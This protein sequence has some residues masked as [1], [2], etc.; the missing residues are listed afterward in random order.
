MRSRLRIYLLLALLS[1]LCRGEAQTVATNSLQQNVA[2]TPK[3]PSRAAAP[4]TALA[5]SP[6]GKSV[7]VGGYRAVRL[8]DPMT[9]SL[10]RTLGGAADQ[11]QAVAWNENGTRLA[12]AGGVPGQSGEVLIFDPA[13]GQ[14]VQRLAGHEE[15]VCAVAWRPHS[16]ELAA[17]SLDKTVRLWDTTTG[18]P[19]RLLKEHADAVYSVAWSPD[20]KLLASGGADRSVKLFDTTTW[21]VVQTLTVHQDTVTQIAF[22]PAGTLLMTASADKTLAV[23]NVKIGSM[24]TPVRRPG[25][26]EMVN[27]CRYSADG[28]LLVCGTAG[29]E[30]KVWNGD[31]AQEKRQWRDAA[32][33][34]YSVAVTPDNRYTLAGTLDGKVFFWDIATGKRV[35]TV[36][37]RPEGVTIE[38]AE[39]GK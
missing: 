5:C 25:F 39:A 34:V 16:L 21:K 18:K 24:E 11:V 28:T 4:V 1:V 20:G 14:I 23:W 10:L 36:T 37:V 32:D 27:A 3:P 7:A 26:G 17:G 38:T 30:V 22:H 31:A 13:T 19:L 2:P 9:G 35:R 6:D 8:L 29:S 33:W 12:V 15:V